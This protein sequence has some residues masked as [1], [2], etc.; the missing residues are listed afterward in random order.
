MYINSLNSIERGFGLAQIDN[1]K[2]IAPLVPALIAG[3][4]SLGSAIVGAVSNH[5][6]NKRQEQLVQG[7]NAYNTPAQ[8]VD[9]FRQAGLNPYMMLGQVN[10]GNQQSIAST[11]AMD[12]SN[13]G[14][15]IG[16]A[17]Q[18]AQQQPLIKAQVRATHADAENKEAD[19]EIKRIDA[20]TELETRMADIEKQ[21]AEKNLTEE[22]RKKLE[23]E[24]KILEEQH[25][26]LVRQVKVQN[27]NTE[28]DTGVKNAQEKNTTE[29]TRGKKLH[30]DADAKWLDSDRSFQQRLMRS[31]E[32]GNYAGA[33]LSRSSA[34][35]NRQMRPYQVGLTKSQMY[36]QHWSNRLAGKNFYWQPRLWSK[37]SDAID[38]KIAQGW[39]QAGTEVFHEINNTIKNVNDAEQKGKYGKYGKKFQKR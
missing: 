32:A 39:V 10:S 36:G 31:Q 29:D 20:S 4:A 7:Q 11:N 23:E 12:Y 9:R 30:N 1:R 14:A 27:D 25:A 28:A 26:E 33:L 17:A 24:R 15:Q 16:A 3:A 13:A 6:N 37:Q 35:T 2:F 38:A 34:E 5:N 19:T 21:L 18:M 22:Q 8:Q